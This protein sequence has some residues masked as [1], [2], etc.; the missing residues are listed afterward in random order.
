MDSKLAVRLVVGVK[1]GHLQIIAE[2]RRRAVVD[3]L[4]I[5]ERRGRLQAGG[6][7]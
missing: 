2:R 5:S 3:A 1:E 6:H 4:C 7:N